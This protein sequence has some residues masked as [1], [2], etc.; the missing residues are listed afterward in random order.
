LQILLK[1]LLRD[2]GGNEI[3][4]QI[5]ND[6][7][8]VPGLEQRLRELSQDI[9]MKKERKF[10]STTAEREQISLMDNFVNNFVKDFKQVNEAY[11][12]LLKE[13]DVIKRNRN[14]IKLTAKNFKQNI[15]KPRSPTSA[16][17]FRRQ[18]NV[19]TEEVS[20]Q[21]RLLGESDVNIVN[22]N[23]YR[24]EAERLQKRL[25]K[26]EKSMLAKL[27]EYKQRNRK[28]VP[29]EDKHEKS[30]SAGNVTINTIPVRVDID[31]LSAQL[32]YSA[33]EIE[34]LESVENQFVNMISE[35]ASLKSQ[36]S[37]MNFPVLEGSGGLCTELTQ[38]GDISSSATILKQL[39]NRSMNLVPYDEAS[40][41]ESLDI[42]LDR[43]EN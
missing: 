39:T 15:D 17:S 23:Q 36:I 1:I 24:K 22:D 3:I 11:E 29:E 37:R 43:C 31:K 6:L 41:T 35:V 14:D 20:E 33:R 19:V 30:V 2:S 21:V 28:P 10:L 34:E 7:S 32:K 42:K 16:V 9:L 40:R 27:L 38:A 5:Q 26:P 13:R 8:Q 12:R 25:T 18:S 4:A